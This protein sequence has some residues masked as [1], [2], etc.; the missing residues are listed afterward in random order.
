LLKKLRG[1]ADEEVDFQAKTRK[2]VDANDFE[3]APE[4]NVENHAKPTNQH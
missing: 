4:E 2:H 1:G 3:D